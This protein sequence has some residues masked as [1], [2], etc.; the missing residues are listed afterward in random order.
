MGSS[1]SNKA[2]TETEALFL[3]VESQKDSNRADSREWDVQTNGESDR[4]K[5]YL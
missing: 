1:I 5:D 3:A 2:L 4:L